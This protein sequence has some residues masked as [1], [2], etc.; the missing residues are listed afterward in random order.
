MTGSITTQRQARGSVLTTWSTGNKQK[1]WVCFLLLPL[2]L[3][4]LSLLNSI[5]FILTILF[6]FLLHLHLTAVIPVS[7]SLTLWSPPLPHKIL[8]LICSKMQAS[9]GYQQSTEYQVAVRHGSSPPLL[10]ISGQD[11][12]IWIIDSQELIKCHPQWQISSTRLTI[13]PQ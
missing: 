6:L 11:N 1:D 10:Y 4:F 3:F 12:S 9:L 8:L 7:S 5:V 2:L 13:F